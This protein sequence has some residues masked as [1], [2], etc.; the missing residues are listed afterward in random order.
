MPDPIILGLN[1]ND[2]FML[3]LFRHSVDI[4]RAGVMRLTFFANRKINW[5][6]TT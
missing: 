4:S 6:Y 1:A 3:K 2:I 5:W